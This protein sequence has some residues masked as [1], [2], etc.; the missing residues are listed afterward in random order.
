MRPARATWATVPA[1][2][3]IGF[4]LV[5]AGTPAQAA[6]QPLLSSA[7]I[8]GSSVYDAPQLFASYRE[9][10]GQPLTED[11]AGAVAA[12][13]A[14][15]YDRD[16]YSRPELH[17]DE[18]TMAAGILRI[19]V[20]EARFTRVTFSGPAGPYEQR[21][22]ALGAQILNSNPVRPAQVQRA[23]QEMRALP[24]VSVTAETAPDEVVRNGFV[25]TLTTTYRAAEALV[26]ISNR[27]TREIGP[28]FVDGQALVN[29]LLGKDE[30]LGAVFTAATDFAEY[31][32]A[33][34]FAEVPLDAR[35]A[36]LSLFG[37]HESSTPLAFPLDQGASYTRTLGVLRV[38]QPLHLGASSTSLAAGLDV[39]N[40]LT[41][42]AG[43]M[44][45]DDRLR[46][47]DLG[48]QATSGNGAGAQYVVALEL[49]KGLD[50]LGS[51]LQATDLVPDPRRRDFL[52]TRLQLTGVFIIDPRWT[53]RLDALT[54]YSSYA[55]PYTEQLKIGG[56]VLGRGFE[57]AEVAGDSGAD[58]R[59][60]LRRDLAHG[61]GSGKVALY[62]YYDYGRVWSHYGSPTES[63]AI[64]AGGLAVGKG[65]LT[66]SV[67]LAQ[68]LIHADVDGSKS[69]RVFFEI[70]GHF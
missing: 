35:G 27:G 12:A 6:T 19:E 69:P 50:G 52:L 70:A 37:L 43:A 1:I 32:A 60:E 55:L 66:G 59:L 23:L 51:E 58:T 25:L 26:R 21:L 24:G 22:A 18:R 42:Q 63:A 2:V 20:F 47:A 30:R 8:S 65:A 36:H 40:Q 46:I 62:A 41:D 10:L 28:V 29:D 34:A 53:V 14:R 38:T 4:V 64:A 3:I 5:A 49:R 33:G 68:P 17:I 31:H 57:V 11:S 13:V 39:D 48:F 16:G 54:Q 15:M 56:E 67:E 45:R 61:F 9:Q 7:V 44:V